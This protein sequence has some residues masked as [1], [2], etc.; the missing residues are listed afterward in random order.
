MISP[1]VIL[2][3]TRSTTAVDH[4]HLKVKEKDVS[5]AKTNCITISIEK[6]SS[7]QKF[8]LKIQ[9]ILGSHELKS[10]D[11]FNHAHPKIT[12]STFSFPEFLPACKNSVYSIHSILRYPFLT[13]STQN[14]FDQILIFVNLYQHAKTQLFNL[15]FFRYSQF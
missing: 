10:N 3:V 4:Q 12:E 14:I 9:Q 11:I 2:R 8:I 7:F 1:W 13:M 5:L 15:S 6:I